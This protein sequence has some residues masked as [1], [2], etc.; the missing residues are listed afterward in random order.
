MSG[1]VSAASTFES[2]YSAGLA[3]SV[4][5]GVDDAEM[6]VQVL[7]FLEDGLAELARVRGFRLVAHDMTLLVLTRPPIRTLI[8][9]DKD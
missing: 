9:R 7:F 8:A 1:T 2:G 3:E 4:G 6:G 5:L